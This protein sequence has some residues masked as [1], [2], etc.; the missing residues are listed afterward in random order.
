M[1]HIWVNKSQKS[2]MKWISAD[3]IWHQQQVLLLKFMASGNNLPI[4]VINLLFIVQRLVLIEKSSSCC[5][6]WC[7]SR[8]NYVLSSNKFFD[9]SIK[10]IIK[11]ARQ[12]CNIGAKVFISQK[13]LVF[14]EK[15]AGHFQFVSFDAS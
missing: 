8:I 6:V 3:I 1:I 5:C 13:S 2:A 14:L 4:F 9:I 7:L 11:L 10:P 12:K 15:V